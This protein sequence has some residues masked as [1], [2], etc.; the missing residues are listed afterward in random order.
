MAETNKKAKFYLH[1]QEYWSKQPATV[2]GMLGGYEFVS[3]SDLQ[4]SQQM[5]DWLFT[6]RFFRQLFFFFL[7]LKNFLKE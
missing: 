6:V 5:I 1:S 3:E 4:Q 2:N 7:N